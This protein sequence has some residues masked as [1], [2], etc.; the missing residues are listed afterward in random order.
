[1]SKHRTGLQR[2]RG[3]A[4]AGGSKS[5]PWLLGVGAAALVAGGFWYFTSRAKAQARPTPPPPPPPPAPGAPP[6]FAVPDMADPTQP[7]T[8]QQAWSVYLIGALEAVKSVAIYDLTRMRLGLKIRTTSGVT[9]RPG[10]AQQERLIR[11]TEAA[12]AVIR[13]GGSTMNDADWRQV[14]DTLRAAYA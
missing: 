4:G 13:G 14:F 9:P 2:R 7:L 11:E 8:E 10:I 5:T 3:F 1:M 12:I 6:P